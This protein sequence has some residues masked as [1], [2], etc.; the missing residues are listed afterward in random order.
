MDEGADKMTVAHT[1]RVIMTGILCAATIGCAEV[2]IRKIPAS[3]NYQDWRNG[4]QARADNI[5]GF[6]YYLPRPY[7]AV[8]QEFPVAGDDF[9]VAGTIGNNG[10]VVSVSSAS[11]PQSIRKLAGTMSE[12]NKTIS[13]SG[14]SIVVS[15]WDDPRP[16]SKG[17]GDPL[18]ALA[19]SPPKTET[20]EKPEAPKKAEEEKTETTT[21]TEGMLTTSG[22]PNTDPLAKVGASCSGV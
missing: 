16:T 13:I 19:D 11:I 17:G 18:T 15:K 21:M 9:L 3:V 1:V 5:P 6:R 2:K 22:D 20:P 12:D 4:D 10:E 7:V 14:G 8:K